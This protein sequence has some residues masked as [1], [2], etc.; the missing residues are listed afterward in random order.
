M[1]QSVGRLDREAE[2]SRF[3]GKSIEGVLIVQAPLEHCRGAL[4]RGTEPTNTQ[5]L[6]AAMDW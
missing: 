1:A 3:V 4:E 5:M 6:T 2:G